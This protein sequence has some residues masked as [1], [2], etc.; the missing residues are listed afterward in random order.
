MSGK[1]KDKEFSGEAIDQGPNEAEKAFGLFRRAIVED[2]PEDAV[3]DDGKK[4]DK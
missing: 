3:Q 1:R 2:D 4:A